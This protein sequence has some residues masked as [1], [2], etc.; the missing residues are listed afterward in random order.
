MQFFIAIR[1]ADGCCFKRDLPP[2]DDQFVEEPLRAR[3]TPL[4]V[5]VTHL[6]ATFLRL[7]QTRALRRGEQ[8]EVSR[9]YADALISSDRIRSKKPILDLSV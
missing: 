2:L 4:A 1:L 5:F 8:D 3:T 9:N 6:L 7:P